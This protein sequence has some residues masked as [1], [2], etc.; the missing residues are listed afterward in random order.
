MASLSYDEAAHLLRRAG[1]G[2]PPEEIEALTARGREG[3]IDFLIDY[4]RIDNRELEAKLASLFSGYFF[5]GTSIREWWAVRFLLTKRPFEEKMTLF[6]HNHFATALSKVEVQYMFTQNLLLRRYA[7]DHFD[8][9]LETVAKDAAMLNWLDTINNVVGHPNENFARE[10]QELFTMGPNDFVSGRPN[11]T[12]KDVKE[13]A[14]AFTGW[15]HKYHFRELKPPKTKF[16]IRTSEHDY[17]PKEVYG[18]VANYEGEDIIKLVCG[19]LE[20]A[21]FLVKELFEFFVFPLK[22]S[23]EDKAIVQRFAGAYM[24]GGR[25]IKELVRAIFVSDEFFSSRARF[26][27]VK[28]PIEFVAGAIRMLG[29][30]LNIQNLGSVETRFSTRTQLMGMDLF[31][32]PDVSGWNLGEG[33]LSTSA[34]IERFNFANDLARS[35]ADASGVPGVCIS[36]EQLRRYMDASPERTVDLLLTCLGPLEIDPDRRRVLVEFLQTD[37][38]GG[39]VPFVADEETANKLVRG[40]VYLVMCL[41]EFQLN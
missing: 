21:H 27:L 11:Y 18:K 33:W 9:L 17:G 15:K 32:P 5:F 37:D 12:E 26:A 30:E 16:F 24:A 34:M 29:L 35:R 20:T 41:P 31:N 25:S 13:V 36:V 28:N 4:D 40:L 1:F 3:A 38:D 19:R 39:R 10:L 8:S 23:E 7:L 2:G 14:R 6:W 22:D